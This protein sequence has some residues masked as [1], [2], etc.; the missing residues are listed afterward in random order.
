MSETKPTCKEV[1]LHICDNLGEE[2][3]S[4]K[5][6]SIRAHMENCNSCNRYFN[7][8]E[9]TIEFYKKYNVELPEKAHN[10]LID[11]LGLKD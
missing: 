4:A 2:L 3:N 9:T 11:M 1:M 10:R 8:V 6:I 5:C 7:S